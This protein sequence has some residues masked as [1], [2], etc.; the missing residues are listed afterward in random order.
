MRESHGGRHA[1]CATASWR[2]QVSNTCASW[3]AIR[4][5][6][7]RTSAAS[8]ARSPIVRRNVAVGRKPCHR[9]RKRARVAGRR[10]QRVLFTLNQFGSAALACRDHGTPTR[11]GFGDHQPERLRRGADVHDHIESAHRGRGLHEPRQ[12]DAIIEMARGDHGLQL[13]V[14]CTDCSRCHTAA[15]RRCSHAAPGERRAPCHRGRRHALS[16]VHT[17][18]Q[19]R[20]G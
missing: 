14:V 13:V 8:R 12:T 4:S 11:H 20:H 6:L 19:V 2:P 3:D 17:W 10:N 7:N 15:R 9:L 1:V 16:I 18:Q 5:G